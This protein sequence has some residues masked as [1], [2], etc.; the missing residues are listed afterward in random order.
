M[1]LAQRKNFINLVLEIIFM[2]TEKSAGAVIFR[3]EKNKKFYLLLHY[4]S[5]HWDFVKGHVEKGEDDETTVRRESKEEADLEKIDFVQGFKETEQYFYK[6][7]KDLIK[8]T[9]VFYLAETA[10]EE[11]KISHEHIGF[12]WANF[13]EASELLTF[14]NSKEIL[15]KADDFLKSHSKQKTLAEF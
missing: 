7:G 4:E 14:K 6:K 8:K 15:K 1:H 2:L 5:G 9:V 11:I 3:I 10:Q 12:K 13:E